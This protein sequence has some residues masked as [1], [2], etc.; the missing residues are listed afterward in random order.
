MS[1]LIIASKIFLSMTSF[2]IL[3]IAFCIAPEVIGFYWP[4]SVILLFASIITGYL[5]HKH[6]VKTSGTFY[7]MKGESGIE[8]YYSVAWMGKYLKTDSYT[9]K[10]SLME[11]CHSNENE[12]LTRVEA[13]RA[14]DKFWA[15][16][17]EGD[18][19][20]S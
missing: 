17:K 16:L 2:L 9:G 1:D 13:D 7:I 18:D 3:P 15:Q 12:Y 19:V 5:H 14:I 20:R 10:V 4:V 8:P 11:M 6:Q